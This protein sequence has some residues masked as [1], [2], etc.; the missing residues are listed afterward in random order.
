M[1][2]K[3]GRVVLVGGCFD[4]LHPGHLIF[5]QKAKKVGDYLIV[6]LESDEKIK[7]AKGSKRP[8]FN[9]QERMQLLQSL[10]MV[11]QVIALP[12]MESDQ[13]YDRLISKI[14][15]AVIAVTK[16]YAPM[17]HYQRVAKMTGA[18]LKFVTKVV[19]NYSSSE[20]LKHLI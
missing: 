11:D 9:Q 7:R 2:K 6:L 16:G 3:L 12:A 14:N 20:I 1:T 10:K 13:D 5:L 8:V 17:H 15:P 18:K 19:G 4:I